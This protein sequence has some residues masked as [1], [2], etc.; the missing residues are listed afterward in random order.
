MLAGQYTY[1]ISRW[2]TDFA[3]RGGNILKTHG[4]GRARS[5]FWRFFGLSEEDYNGPL[6]EKWRA[7]V[8]MHSQISSDDPPIYAMTGGA[9]RKPTNAGIYNHHPYHALLIEQACKANGVE[10]MCLVPQVREEDA[11]TLRKNP[12]A[13]M[14]FLFKHLGV[15]S[16]P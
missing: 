5:E 8:D 14:E 12:N 16:R 15:D 1:D 6:G 13:M 11:E 3:S 10:V 9:D 2:D 7:D 4:R